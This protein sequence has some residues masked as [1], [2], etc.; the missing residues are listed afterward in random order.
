MN[1]QSFLAITAHFIEPDSSTL[2]S[3]L[4]GCI[5]FNESHTATNLSSFLFEEVKKWGIEA[6]LKPIEHI[7]DKIKSMVQFFKKSSHSLSKLDE[8]QK[9]MGLQELKLKQG[10]P[11]R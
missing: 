4:L 5:E 11:T 8:V 1:N 6:G 2:H 7:L 10:V 9:Q 3:N